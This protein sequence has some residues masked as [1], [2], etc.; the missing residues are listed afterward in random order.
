MPHKPA[1]GKRNHH[2]LTASARIELAEMTDIFE[3]LVNEL[4]RLQQSP[5]LKNTSEISQLIT[6]LALHHSK[7]VKHVN[8]IWELLTGAET[9]NGGIEAQLAAINERLDAHDEV[10]RMVQ[11]L[12]REREQSKQLF[13]ESAK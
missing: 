1:V 2:S 13:G 8:G 10:I 3:R 5:G 7:T 12:I 6:E 9:E 4:R 11:E